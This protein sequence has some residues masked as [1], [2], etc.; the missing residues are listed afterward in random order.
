[1]QQVTA[2]NACLGGAWGTV[3]AITSQV[4]QTL[5]EPSA[6]ELC[7]GRGLGAPEAGSALTV[8]SAG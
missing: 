7:L 4:V 5:Q 8:H 3:A 2:E 1:M 6:V